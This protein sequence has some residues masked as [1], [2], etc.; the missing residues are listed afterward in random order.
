MI[1]FKP[2]KEAFKNI[3]KKKK[4][5]LYVSFI[6]GKLCKENP[7]IKEQKIYKI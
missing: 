7:K 5:K 6:Y 1:F 2:Y 3:E 4:K